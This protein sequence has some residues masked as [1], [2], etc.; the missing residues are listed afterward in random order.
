[1]PAPSL[2]LNV[3]VD[4]E[5]ALLLRS[6]A[7]T[8][9]VNVSVIV[10]DALRRVLGAVSSEREAGWYEGRQAAYVAARRAIERGIA[11]IPPVPPGGA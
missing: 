2:H 10:R 6:R 11:E 9:G 3:K 7:E 5:L 8:Q 4:R 1:M